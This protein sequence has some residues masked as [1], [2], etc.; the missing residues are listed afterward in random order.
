MKTKITEQTEPSYRY[1]INISRS[2]KG[3]FTFDCTVEGTDAPMEEVLQKSD[4]L[5]KELVA[6][7]PS[8]LPQ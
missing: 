6:R 3:V 2:V 8:E 5:R 1:R 4:D 7:Y